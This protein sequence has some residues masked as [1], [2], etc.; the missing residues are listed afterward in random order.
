MHYIKFKKM[1][2]KN[3][4][5]DKYLK[6]LIRLGKQFSPF[7]GLLIIIRSYLTNNIYYYMFCVIFRALFL[8]MISG[9]YM[10]PLLHINSQVI[11]DSTKILSINYLF[12]NFTTSYFYYIKLCSA[13]YVLMLFRL[14]LILYISNQFS[15]YKLKKK[16]PT[17]FKYQIILDHLVFLFF[18]Y[19][20]EFLAIPYYV[21]FLEDKFVIKSEG[22]LEKSELVSIMIINTFLIFFYNLQN[23]LF[24]ICANKNYTNNDSEAILGTQNVKAFENSYVSYRDSNLS[25][26]C[27]TIIQNVPLIKNIENYIGDDSV[28]YYKFSI[29]I[30]LILLFIILIREKLYFIFYF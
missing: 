20:L 27:F 11:Q 3:N 25:F 1:E 5:L 7:D 24:M 2:F 9:N 22:R 30:I 12:E 17:P 15:K 4:Q 6:L 19:L 18:P 13:L 28:K 21:Y 8:I 10:N 26:L 29:S 23:Y 16:F 14:I